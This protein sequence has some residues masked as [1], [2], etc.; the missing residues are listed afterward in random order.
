MR[1]AN[2]TV[3]HSPREAAG[4]KLTVPSTE[5]TPTPAREKKVGVK[6]GGL[7]GGKE[8][9]R[10]GERREEGRWERVGDGKS[11]YSP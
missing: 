1:L 8:D 7:R 2:S 4:P 9:G 5:V 11:P 10:Y 6:I 3:L